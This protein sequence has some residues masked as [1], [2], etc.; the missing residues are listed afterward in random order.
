[1][2]QAELLLDSIKVVRND[3]SDSDLEIVP[4]RSSGAPAV[5]ESSV[6]AEQS[7]AASSES[8]PEPADGRTAQPGKAGPA[9]A[10]AP[11]EPAWGGVSERL[12]SG[13][14]T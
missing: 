10:G 8:L 13:R 9:K 6:Q 11:N 7:D 12:F 3:L 1:M 2:V 14:K 4:V 5:T